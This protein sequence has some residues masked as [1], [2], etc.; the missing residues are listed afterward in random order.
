MPRG[1]GIRTDGMS[2]GNR[3]KKDGNEWDEKQNEQTNRTKT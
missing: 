3:P 2:V 1:Y